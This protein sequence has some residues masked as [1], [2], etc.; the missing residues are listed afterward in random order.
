MT[1][2][3]TKHFSNL[4]PHGCNA[5]PRTVPHNLFYFLVCFMCHSYL[6]FAPEQIGWLCFPFGRTPSHTYNMPNS[7]VLFRPFFSPLSSVY[8]KYIPF[9]INMFSI[10]YVTLSRSP[11]LVVI[12]FVGNA[13]PGGGPAHCE[14]TGSARENPY[15]C[16]TYC[17]FTYGLLLFF[18]VHANFVLHPACFMF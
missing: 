1:V 14:F 8:H 7:T 2:Y 4:G 10:P 12:S 6:Q 3:D 15:Q 16:S 5:W 11:R 9:S 18:F 13:C 17:V